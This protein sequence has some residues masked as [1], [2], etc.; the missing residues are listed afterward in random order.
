MAERK[1]SVRQQKF[2]DL[3][4]GN[5][6]QAARLAGYSGSEQALGKTA[7]DLLRNPKIQQAIQGRQDTETR[8]LIAARHNRQAW[9]TQVMNDPDTDMRD[10]LRASELLGRSE[11]DFLERVEHG[12]QVALP[13]R[14]ILDLSGGHQR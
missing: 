14:F 5:G 10:R 6:T 1:L 3:Y 11:G 8:P 13:P 4:E 7:H 12:G 2:A 9:W